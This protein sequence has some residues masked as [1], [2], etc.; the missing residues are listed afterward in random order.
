MRDHLENLWVAFREV[1]AESSYIALASALALGAFLFAVWL[2]NIGLI[3]D[4]FSTSTAPLAAKFK[5]AASLLLGIGTNFSLLSAGY[6]IAIA[7][8]FGINGAMIA[9][10]ARRSRE[11]IGKGNIIAGGSGISAG[12]LG[13]GCAACGSFLLTAA[14]SS[15]G[16]AGAIALLP[17]RGGEFGLISVPLLMVSLVLISKKIAEPL[18]CKDT[19]V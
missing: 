14:L 19:T 7:I 8:L 16:A 6:T 2:P 10:L 4:V 18:V 12:V 15:F 13:I 5:V 11:G 3:T 17:L 9:R 1:F